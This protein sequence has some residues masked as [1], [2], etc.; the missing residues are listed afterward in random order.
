MRS[1]SVAVALAL[2]LLTGCSNE[3][4]YQ[5]AV[6]W[7]INGMVPS[8]ERCQEQ[9]IARARFV[10]RSQSGKTLQTLEE[11]C[12]STLVLSDGN[13]Y[14]GFLTTRSF[15]WDTRY[16]FSLSLVDASGKDVSL[17][18][19][20]SFYVPYAEADIFELGYLDYVQPTGQAASLG[21]EWSVGSNPDL[22]A[23]CAQARL[24]TVQILAA[25]AL[26]TNFENAFPVLEAPCSAGQMSSNNGTTRVPILATGYYQFKYIL[27][28]E[29]GSVVPA[30][31]AVL[32]PYVVPDV[33]DIRLPRQTFTAF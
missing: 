12:G 1:Y 14:G 33:Q 3:R 15:E 31:T 26:D 8:P 7:L 16:S 21:G 24:K 27:V 32:G 11:D 28:S 22:V 19:S 20:D 5:V 6:S 25:S 9:G 18:A 2:A 30:N 10:V 13:E 17:A 29:G 4:D 23:A